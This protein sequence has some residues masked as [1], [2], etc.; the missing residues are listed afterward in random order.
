M[1]KPKS[2]NYGLGITIFKEGA[3]LA[4]Y[5]EAL[6]LAFKEDSA[7]LIEE[8]LPGTEYRFFVLDNQVRAI[9]L[10]VPANVVGDGVRSVEA[11]VAEKI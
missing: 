5:M 6:R 11:L 1:I 7:I 2:T 8:F 4:D 9:L 3:S 10:R